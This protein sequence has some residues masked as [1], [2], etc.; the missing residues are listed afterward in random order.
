MKKTIFTFILLSITA[1]LWAQ[2]QDTIAQKQDSVVTYDELEKR[3]ALLTGADI[4]KRRYLNLSIGT[5][6]LKFSSYGDIPAQN[7]KSDQSL[8]LEY[9]RTYFINGK[10]PVA[11]MIRFGIDISW[12]DLQYASFTING[13]D[14]YDL[15]VKTD[16]HFINTGLQIG[17]S[18]TVTPKKEFNFKA[19][20]HYAPSMTFFALSD[21]SDLKTGYAGYIT[22]GVHASYKFITLGME[23]RGATANMSAFSTDSLE[24]IGSDIDIDDEDSLDFGDTMDDLLPKVKTKLPGFRFILGFRF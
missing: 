20:V 17:P 1:G 8:S 7:L 15:P 6:Q 18:V 23:F 2:E 12:V 22:G 21:F 10:R 5:Q 24:D 11:N 4:P 16:S 19:Y 3:I 9:G 13:T 14:E